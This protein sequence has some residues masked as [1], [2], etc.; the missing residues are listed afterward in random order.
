MEYFP[1]KCSMIFNDP[2]NLCTWPKQ[3]GL[4]PLNIKFINFV[5]H[6]CNAIKHKQ[7][8]KNKTKKLLY[9]QQCIFLQT[10]TIIN[11]SSPNRIKEFISVKFNWLWHSDFFSMNDHFSNKCFYVVA[12]NIKQAE[13][14]YLHSKEIQNRLR[15]GNQNDLSK[16]GR[17]KV[18]IVGHGK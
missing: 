13:K 10:M 7:T 12:R 1:L 18:K 11:A 2:L 17:N 3:S 14:A 6:P 8:K 15:N 4:N 5:F 16:I 9:V